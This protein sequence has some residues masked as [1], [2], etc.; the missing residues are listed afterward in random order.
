MAILIG[1]RRWAAGIPASNMGGPF[2]PSKVGVVGSG[3]AYSH[4][5]IYY[6]I[7]TDGG[8]GPRCY[9][10]RVLSHGWHHYMA[11]LKQKARLILGHYYIGA[12]SWVRS[13]CHGY[14]HIS[15]LVLWPVAQKLF[16]CKCKCLENLHL[17]FTSYQLPPL[18]LFEYLAIYH[19]GRTV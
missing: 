12:L 7:S 17:F 6:S 19:R 16:D 1:I 10:L 18:S 15:R 5:H 9:Q 14:W 4:R 13:W 11:H 8:G 3:E 2:S